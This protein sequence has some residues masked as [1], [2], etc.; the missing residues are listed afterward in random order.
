M[1]T[2][3][4]IKQALNF[5]NDNVRRPAKKKLTQ[6]ALAK[7]LPGSMP[8]KTKGEYITHYIKGERECPL[9][10]LA[11]ISKELCV[12]TDFLLGIQTDP[13]KKGSTINIKLTASS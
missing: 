13:L 9:E 2:K 3:I 4:R 11:A 1:Y 12:T 8:D 5:Y 7:K 6:Q 10:M